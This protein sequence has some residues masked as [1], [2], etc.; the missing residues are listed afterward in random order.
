ML[1]T[2]HLQTKRLSLHK[3]KVLFHRH[4]LQ[5]KMMRTSYL[6]T[7]SIL[8]T[9][10]AMTI[11]FSCDNKPSR[12][13]QRKAEIRQQDSTDLASARLDMQEADSIIAFKEIELEDLKQ[14]FVFEKQEKYQTM[15]YYVLPQHAGNKSKFKFFPEV[16]E[17]GKLLLVN[18]D[19]QRRYTFTEID[20]NKDDYTKQL[21]SNLS[22]KDTEAVAKCHALAITMHE[23]DK[24]K[25]KKE[26]AEIKIRFYKE[27]KERQ[28]F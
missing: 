28:S 19:K 7:L 9:A 16:E 25:K 21:P 12:V 10:S 5:I 22:S 23:L 2:C 24:A 8:L 26:K 20:L 15:G 18:I 14:G 11:I 4:Q 3:I 6:K 17:S 13:E 27:K 1:I